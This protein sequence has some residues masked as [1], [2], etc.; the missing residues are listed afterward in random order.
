MWTKG[1]ANGLTFLGTVGVSIP[2]G[3]LS[4][5]SDEFLVRETLMDG[6]I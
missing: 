2:A 3:R 6:E 5:D 1:Y 4:T